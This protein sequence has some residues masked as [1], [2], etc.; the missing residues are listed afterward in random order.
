MRRHFTHNPL[1]SI[2]AG[3]PQKKIFV[4]EICGKCKGFRCCTYFHAMLVLSKSLRCVCVQF[5]KGILVDTVVSR[6]VYLSIH[7][8]RDR[9]PCV[10]RRQTFRIAIARLHRW[11]FLDLQ[12]CVSLQAVLQDCFVLNNVHKRIFSR[13]EACGLCPNFSWLVRFNGRVFSE[14]LIGIKIIIKSKALVLCGVEMLKCNSI[15]A[16]NFLIYVFTY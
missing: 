2:T 3:H 12:G 10:A 9:K 6:V 7:Q 8:L 13:F 16:S 5:Y 11:V 1:A 14:S 4:L 15:A